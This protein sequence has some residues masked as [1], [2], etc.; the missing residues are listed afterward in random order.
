MV[1]ARHAV[2]AFLAVGARVHRGR[3]IDT[4]K[5]R[6]ARCR[7][8]V[9]PTKYVAGHGPFLRTRFEGGI[10]TVYPLLMNANFVLVLCTT[11]SYLC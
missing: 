1:I 5:A 3:L 10:V 7:A 4:A 8:R 6:S 11:T 9:I 2:L